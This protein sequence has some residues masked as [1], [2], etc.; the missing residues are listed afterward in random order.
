M[1][2]SQELFVD[3]AILDGTQSVDVDGMRTDIEGNLYV[4]RNGGQEVVVFSPNKVVLSRIK[5]NIKSAANLELAG[6]QGKTM[7]IVGKC[8]DDETK[9]CVDKFENNIPGKAFTLLNR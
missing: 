1:V 7:F 6:D 9:G 8:L 2:S 4:T 5:L 3:F